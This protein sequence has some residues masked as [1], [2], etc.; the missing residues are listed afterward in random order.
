M[1]ARPG[2]AYAVPM[3]SDA[4]HVIYL[5]RLAPD[6]DWTVF[7]SVCATARTR[8]ADEGIAGV[9]LFDGERF[10]QW[11]QGPAERVASLMRAITADARHTDLRVLLQAPRP[12]AAAAGSWRAGFVDA[13]A[14][15]AFAAL[16][17]ADP[18]ALLDGLA[19]LIACA[20]LEPAPPSGAPR[21]TPPACGMKES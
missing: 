1:R 20:D 9:L 12:A 21:A 19:R 18:E 7:G 8:N 5:S 11:L 10:L 14:M 4:Q 6:R 16:D 2:V 17:T 15:D 13:E 3:K